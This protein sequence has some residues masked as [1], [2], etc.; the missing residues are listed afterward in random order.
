MLHFLSTNYTISVTSMMFFYGVKLI[1]YTIVLDWIILLQFSHKF[2]WN[3]KS[4]FYKHTILWS[5]WVKITYLTNIRFFQFLIQVLSQNWK[6][7]YKFWCI[8]NNQTV[9]FRIISRTGQNND[10]WHKKYWVGYY[11]KLP[12]NKRSGV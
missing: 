5:M 8:V 9:Y 11:S 10:F 2:R 12:N 3:W 6:K 7:Y 4:T 1:Q